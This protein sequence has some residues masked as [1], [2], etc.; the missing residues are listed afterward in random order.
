MGILFSICFYCI[1]KP[2]W[3]GCVVLQSQLSQSGLVTKF[4][5]AMMKGQ[6][7]GGGVGAS[8]GRNTFAQPSFHPKGL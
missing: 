1:A 8:Q 5:C 6:S 7:R 3:V 2:L 4:L